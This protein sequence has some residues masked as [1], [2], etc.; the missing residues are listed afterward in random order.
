MAGRK[1][2][3]LTKL[4][5]R[6]C[7]EYVIDLNGAAAYTRAGYKSNTCV[8]ASKSAHNLLKNTEVQA[9]LAKVKAARSESTGVTAERVLQELR[10][11]AFGRVTDTVEV[12]NGVSTIKDTKDWSD[13]S[14]VCIQEVNTEGERVGKEGET[15]S[16][17]KARVKAY[18]K[19]KAIEILAKHTGVSNDHDSAI[20]TL[21]TYGVVLKR[22]ATTG[23]YYVAD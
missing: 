5:Q 2:G 21:K 23:K 11:I 22:D 20:A 16:P 7:E 1:P 3:Q 15:S 10:A 8:T 13:E 17:A 4:Q 12:V 6:F 18:D 19:M 9:Y 14:R